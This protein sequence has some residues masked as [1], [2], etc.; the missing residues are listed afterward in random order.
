[1]RLFAPALLSLLLSVAGFFHSNPS[2]AQ[3][4][5]AALDSFFDAHPINGVLLLAENGKVVYKKGFGTADFGSGAPNT[6]ATPFNLASVS[7]VITATAVLQL[8]ERGKLRLDDPVAR[9]LAGFPYPAITIRHLLTHTSGLPNLELY[10]DLVA[11]YP[12]TVLSNTAILLAL[13]GWKKPLPFAPGD[14][15]RYSNTN[16]DL[17][18][19]V[20]E[21]LSGVSYPRYLKQHIFDPAGMKASFVA[22]HPQKP[23]G[24]IA[25]VQPLWYSHQYVPADSVARYRYINY[26]LS[27][28]YGATNIVATVQDLLLFDGALFS[29]KLLRPETLALAHTPVR[30]NDGSIFYEGSM[31]TMPGEGRGSYGMGW[32]LFEQPAFGNSVGHGGYNYGLATFYFHRLQPRQTLI[33]FDNTASPGFGR[34]VSAAL[35]LLNGPAP[36]DRPQKTSVARIYGSTLKEKG[37][38]AATVVL[39][40]LKGDTARYYTSERELNWLGYDFLRADFDDHLLLALEVFKVNTL[41]F[42]KSFNVFDSY[43]EA[44]LKAGKKNLA[45]AMYQKS[46]ALNPQNKGGKAALEKLL[47]E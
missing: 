25:Q 41:L 32:S 47:H 29:G 26:N 23:K 12:D 4:T 27:G 15:W 16:Y 30:L 17:L 45:I 38:D 3:A 34:A 35:H 19:L 2:K 8:M 1:M 28:L 37:I 10:E 43:A 42:P 40:Q 14:Q 31:D 22:T 46:V 20:I 24:A 36:P 33:A 9:H 21:K 39:H 13:R 6:L 18:A 44:L 7:K 11:Q 5:V